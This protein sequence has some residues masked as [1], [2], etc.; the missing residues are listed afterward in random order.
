MLP[1]PTVCFLG[2]KESVIAAAVFVVLDISALRSTELGNSC[3]EQSEQRDLA[4]RRAVC[5]S[6]TA[7]WHLRRAGLVAALR[8]LVMASNAARAPKAPRVSWGKPGLVTSM[9]RREQ[10]HLPCSQTTRVSEQQTRGQSGL[11]MEKQPLQASGLSQGDGSKDVSA[12]YVGPQ[13]PEMFKQPLRTKCVTRQVSGNELAQNART[14]AHDGNVQDSIMSTARVAQNQEGTG[15]TLLLGDLWISD[16]DPLQSS[17]PAASPQAVA[18]KRVD[19]GGV[20]GEAGFSRLSQQDALHEVTTGGRKASP[21]AKIATHFISREGDD[22][23]PQVISGNPRVLSTGANAT[24]GGETGQMEIAENFFSLSDQLKESDEDTS[25]IEIDSAESYT[26]SIW[27]S[28][29]L[30]CRSKLKHPQLSDARSQRGA[31]R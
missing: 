6:G 28:S 8:W 17:R 27:G 30:N 18:G 29:K 3:K 21:V 10:K 19:L 24:R 25:S 31:N 7:S 22:D 20:A 16:S 15:M 1:P 13:I 12:E 14:L 5:I 4:H 23:N 26:V 9:E 2:M 11:P